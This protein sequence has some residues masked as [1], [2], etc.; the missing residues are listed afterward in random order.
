MLQGFTTIAADRRL[1][2]ITVLGLAQTFT[3]GC[4]T[5]FAV[6]VAID[7]WT[8]EIRASVS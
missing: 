8:W 4:L 2:L 7:S 3:R 6:V 5:V 1:G